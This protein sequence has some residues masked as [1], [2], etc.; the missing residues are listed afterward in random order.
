MQIVYFF[1]F[2]PK[3]YLY[4]ENINGDSKS[5]SKLFRFIVELLAEL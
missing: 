3:Q 5:L 1:I 4:E 2:K